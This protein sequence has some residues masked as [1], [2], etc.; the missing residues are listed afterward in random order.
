MSKKEQELKKFYD[1]GII[2]ETAY[3]AQLA[4]LGI[5]QQ[6]FERT[7]P[8][9]EDIPAIPSPETIPPPIITEEKPYGFQEPP[10]ISQTPPPLPDFK[11]WFILT[12]GT[13]SGPFTKADLSEMGHADQFDAKTFVWKKGM[14]DWTVA[15]NITE[16]TDLLAGLPPPVPHVLP[17]MVTQ[18]VK[19]LD[20]IFE[21]GNDYYKVENYEKA[22][23]CF[24][25][26][27]E[28]G[29]AG[30]Q[31]ELAWC[32]YFGDGVPEDKEKG[33]D[34]FCKALPQF[35]KLAKEEDTV[36]QYMLGQ[37]YYYRFGILDDFEK[38][39]RWY[40]KAADAGYAEAQFALGHCYE[41]GRGVPKDK[42][43]AAEWYRKAAAQ[44]HGDAKKCLEDLENEFIK[45]LE[46]G[47]GPVRL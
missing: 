47:A 31:Y 23:E 18:I 3:K 26:A 22:I 5:T 10:P 16:L 41:I 30:A 19:D 9:V 12:N 38:A 42:E 4:E 39:A 6:S 17:Q 20:A 27:G 33:T 25:E 45:D 15:E 37:C 32:Y 35:Q 44:G 14:T 46:K 34:W 24:L 36:S 11:E 7:E 29:H 13:K 40:R 1:L 21:Q 43:K 8:I 2:D 28:E